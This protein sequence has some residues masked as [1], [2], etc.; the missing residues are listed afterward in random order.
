MKNAG[1]PTTKADVATSC[2]LNV[3]AG[4]TIDIVADGKPDAPLFTTLIL[5][6]PLVGD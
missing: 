2:E 3:N 6:Y 5:E 4:I 1:A